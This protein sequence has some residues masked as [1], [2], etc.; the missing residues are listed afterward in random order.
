MLVLNRA[1]GERIRLR[2]PAGAAGE[3]WI[4]VEDIRAAYVKLGIEAPRS[5]EI[6]REELAVEKDR[7]SGRV[8]A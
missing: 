6:D 1:C 8:P 4:G 7:D 3:A 5:V 2:W